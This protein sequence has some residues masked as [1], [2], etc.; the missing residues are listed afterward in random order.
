MA[1]C[2]ETDPQKARAVR[3]RTGELQAVHADV[4]RE[5]LAYLIFGMEDPRD[6]AACTHLLS[7]GKGM[8]QIGTLAADIAKVVIYHVEGDSP[9]EE[10]PEPGRSAASAIPPQTER[11]AGGLSRRQDATASAR[12]CGRSCAGARPCPL[13]CCAC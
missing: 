8:E 4:F 5:L 12:G 11:G 1:A 9:D 7:I 6:V 2:A 10:L 3:S 13:G